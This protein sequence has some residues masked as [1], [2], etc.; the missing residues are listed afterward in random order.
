MQ[1]ASCG[2]LLLCY[3]LLSLP[4]R[5]LLLPSFSLL[6]RLSQDQVDTITGMA[7]EQ[8]RVRDLSLFVIMQLVVQV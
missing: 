8:A 3:L 6:K 7:E 2:P 5:H 1:V 4:S